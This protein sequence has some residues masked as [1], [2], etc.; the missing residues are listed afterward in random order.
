MK[1]TFYLFIFFLLLGGI[2]KSQSCVD[3]PERFYS[4]SQAIKAIKAAKFKF[5]DNLPNGKSSWIVRATYY[6]CNGI[7]GYLVYTTD[8]GKEYVH[9]KVPIRVW[10]EF[11]YANSSGSYYVK[12]IKGRFQIVT[13]NS[14]YPY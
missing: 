9:E 2:V 12:Y 1:K 13:K 3:L 6:S 4:Y 7:T 10:T 8:K 5:I 11:K 14:K